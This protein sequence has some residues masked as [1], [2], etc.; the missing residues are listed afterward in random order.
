MLGQSARRAVG[1][2]GERLGARKIVT[3]PF[4]SRI[5]VSLLIGSGRSRASPYQIC[6]LLSLSCLSSCR[7]MSGIVVMFFLITYQT[8]QATISDINLARQFSTKK[9]LTVVFMAMT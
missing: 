4:D 9:R 2:R 5:S 6:Y 8:A 7:H 3:T 1:W